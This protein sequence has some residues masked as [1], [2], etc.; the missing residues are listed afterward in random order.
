MKVAFVQ[1]TAAKT[2]IRT[3]IAPIVLR[4]L[5]KLLKKLLKLPQ[6]TPPQIKPPQTQATTPPA[7]RI[8]PLTPTLVTS[9]RAATFQPPTNLVLTCA[10]P[11]TEVQ[12][13]A[14]I[15]VITAAFATRMDRA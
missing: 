5:K 2:T 13:T 3:T 11:L 1:Q 7:L 6:L 9:H 14:L 8:T 12:Q 10:K 4:L 15:W